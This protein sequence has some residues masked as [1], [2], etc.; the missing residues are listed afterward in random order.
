MPV[1]LLLELLEK[2]PAALLGLAAVH[3]EAQRLHRVAVDQHVHLHQLVLLEA[4]DVVV[5]GAVAAGD[6]LQL[7]EEVVDNLGQRQVVFENLAVVGEELLAF[8]NPAPA[9]AQL[10]DV[11]DAAGGRDDLRGHDGLADAL[12]LAHVRQLGGVGD[13]DDLALAALADAVDLVGHRGR[14]LHDA[15]PAFAFEP[16]LDDVHVQHAQEAAAEAAAQGLGVGGLV[17]VAGVV[18]V[19]TRDGVAQL[20]EL[21]VAAGVEVAVDHRHRL[22]IAFECFVAAGGVERDGVADV[23]VAQRLDRGDHVAHV[24]GFE[25]VINL[26]HVRAELAQL[27]DL[28]GALG[29]HHEDAVAFFH[30]PVDHTEVDH[31]PAVVVVDRVEDQRLQ[32]GLGV[33]LGRRE[34]LA[35]GV[36]Q[37]VDTDAG[38]GAGHDAVCRVQAQH[39]FDLLGTLVGLSAGKID[40]VDDRDQF[41]VG[42]DG[43]VKVGHGLGL[44]ALGGVDHQDGSLAG[45]QGP[46]DFVVEVDVPRG[47]D[48]VQLVG[49]AVPDVVHRDGRGFNGD[50]PFALQVHVVEGLF[51]RIAF[52]HH[53]GAL[54]H[55]VGQGGLA[56]IDVRD[57][58]EVAD[59]SRGCRLVRRGGH[60]RGIVEGAGRR[61]DK[62]RPPDLFGD[63][64]A[65]R[66]RPFR[67]HPD[68]R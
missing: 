45:G 63:R 24:A 28:E 59:V 19:Q 40:L 53:A 17:V 10:H 65:P 30:P 32:R 1:D 52:I 14:G 18:D 64:H 27:G 54:Q 68:P 55:A 39:V 25:G 13:L 26:D 60:S 34:A 51:A 36:E 35:D 6:A 7:V 2:V 62:A 29:A 9:V 58:A 3:D 46:A 44:D 61:A 4:G 50:A 67:R 47:V 48:E 11:A 42:V 33:A 57:D 56:V 49:L 8:I 15:D 23:D 43:L 41:E 16:L 66:H 31:H 20:V 38:L 5:H 12:D 21:R 22:F 37:L